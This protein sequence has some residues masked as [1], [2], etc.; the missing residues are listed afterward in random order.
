MALEIRVLVTCG[1]QREGHKGSFGGAGNIPVLKLGYD[2][3]GVF[4][5]SQFFQ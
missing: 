2:Y 3:V 1:E 5:L 4:S